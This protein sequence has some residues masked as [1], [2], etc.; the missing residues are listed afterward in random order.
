LFFEL[1]SEHV[2]PDCRLFQDPLPD[3]R[4]SC[5]AKGWLPI[6]SSI[7]DGDFLKLSAEREGVRVEAR[8]NIV[9]NVE[10]G[11]NG[12][13]EI[14]GGPFAGTGTFRNV[15]REERPDFTDFFVCHSDCP[16]RATVLRWQVAVD[17]W[18]DVAS[19]GVDD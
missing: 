19:V 12:A 3:L 4:L 5:V 10:G 9:K 1:L 18:L 2:K 17:G 15:R 7:K 13:Y 6:S 14:K 16:A 8:F 11:D